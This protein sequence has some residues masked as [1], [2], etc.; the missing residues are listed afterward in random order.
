MLNRPSVGKIYLYQ[1]L[2][3]GLY[4]FYWCWHSRADIHQA[5]RQALIP[6][7][8][9]L[10]IPGLNFWWMWQYAHAL[11]YVTH[12][13]LKA[14]DTF[15]LYIIGLDAWLIVDIFRF[16]SLLHLTNGYVVLIGVYILVEIGGLSFFCAAVQKRINSLL[17]S[18]PVSPL[19]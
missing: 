7:T 9:F 15:L 12:K 5:A 18:S 19:T 1:F 14:N 11:E 17:P 2:T 4:F 13:R 6:A 16:Q 8:W 10:A 3:L